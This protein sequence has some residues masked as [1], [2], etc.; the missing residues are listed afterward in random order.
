[1]TLSDFVTIGNF[2]SDLAVV[3]SLVYLSLQVRQAEKNQRA[4]VHQTRVDRVTNTSL[5]FSQPEM[6]K[7]LAKVAAPDAE[8]S[9]DEVIQLLYCLRTQMVA[10]DDALWQHDAGLLDKIYFETTRL[11]T[12]RMLANP[13]MRATWTLLR[14]QIA[15]HL[16]DRI[17]RLV[18]RDMPLAAPLNWA[19]AWKQAHADVLA[20]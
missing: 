18:I 13:A 1:M 4:I 12:A 2:V 5:A 6:A 11:N 16:V 19:S 3:A 8:P 14:P 10:F 15:P 9:A 20:G 7:L 17:E